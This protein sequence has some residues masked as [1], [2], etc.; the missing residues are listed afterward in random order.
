M[1]IDWA[2]MMDLPLEHLPA[3]RV[4]PSLRHGPVP[5][6][7]LSRPRTVP[8]GGA[9]PYVYTGSFGMR[10]GSA[11]ALPLPPARL[12]V[13]SGV[14]GLRTLPS[15]RGHLCSSLAVSPRGSYG[16]LRHPHAFFVGQQGVIGQG[17]KG[18]SFI[19]RG[20]QISQTST[21]AMRLELRARGIALP[22]LPALQALAKSFHDGFEAF[23]VRSASRRSGTSWYTIFKEADADGSGIIQLDEFKRVARRTIGLS[24]SKLSD[25]GIKALFCALDSDDS[26]GVPYDEFKHFLKLYTPKASAGPRWVGATQELTGRGADTGFSFVSHGEVLEQTPTTTLRAELAAKGVSLPDSGRLDKLSR[27]FNE[28]LEEARTKAL[29]NQATQ[30]NVSWFQLF[31]QIDKDGSGFITYDE[32]REISRRRDQ[33]RLLRSEVSDEQLKALWC[34]LDVDDS[35]HLTKDE[36]GAFLKRSPVEHHGVKRFGVSQDNV[37]GKGLKGFSFIARG[38]ELRPPPMTARKANPVRFELPMELPQTARS[39]PATPRAPRV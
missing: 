28:R 36:F 35:N 10:P 39:T 33:L 4:K 15:P 8:T 7:R 22:D 20:A 18:F 21:K 1:A 2:A 16:P 23:L 32:M 37:S 5:D 30:T 9:R 26:S 38:A 31:N 11:N 6:L 17:D 13:K 34:R 3:L 29:G 12:R 24:Q 14:S 25:D 27:L 19:A